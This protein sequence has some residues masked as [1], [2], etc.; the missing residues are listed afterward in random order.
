MA[1]YVELLA[2]LCAVVVSVG[3]YM[4]T[5]DVCVCLC[6]CCVSNQNCWHWRSKY[7][8]QELQWLILSGKY[9]S[10]KGSTSIHGIIHTNMNSIDTE[11]GYCRTVQYCTTSTMHYIYY[12]GYVICLSLKRWLY[13][14]VYSL[15]RCWNEILYRCSKA[16]YHD[17][18][19]TRSCSE[20]SNSWTK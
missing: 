2:L 18:A 6:I 17:D 10:T 12:Y 14:C 11:D 19:V 9:V 13:N 8:R 15:V 16:I 3:K 4:P 7:V 20:L 5:K 1:S